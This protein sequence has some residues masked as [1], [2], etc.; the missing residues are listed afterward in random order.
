ML[1]GELLRLLTRSCFLLL[2]LGRLFLLSLR[3]LLRTCLPSFTV[4]SPFP[5]ALIPLS[6][7]KVRL[8]LTLALSPIRIWYFEQ[9]AL[10]LFLLAKTTLAYLPTAFSVAV[11]PLFSFRE[12]VFFAAACAFLHGLCWSRQH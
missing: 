7:A 8:S 1:Q 9:T 3:L 11:R 12:R 6:L 10:F 4:V 5:L 2:L